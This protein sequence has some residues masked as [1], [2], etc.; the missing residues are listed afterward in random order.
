M[1]DIYE[2]RAAPTPAT[3][4]SLESPI[5]KSVYAFVGAGDYFQEPSIC[6]FNP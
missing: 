4:T 1:L 2:S 5:I 3:Q 6:L